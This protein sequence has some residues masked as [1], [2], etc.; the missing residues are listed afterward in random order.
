MRGII[1]RE[2]KSVRNKTFETLLH[3]ASAVRK[4][5]SGRGRDDI[6]REN[7][8]QRE[9]EREGFREGVVEDPYSRNKDIFRSSTTIISLRPCFFISLLIYLF[10]SIIPPSSLYY[11]S[12]PTF[13]FYVAEAAGQ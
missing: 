5:K 3:P 4:N 7:E 13:V 6:E 11:L 8:P 2:K 10:F 9:R 1:K 12:P